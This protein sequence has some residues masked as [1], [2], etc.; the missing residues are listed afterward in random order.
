MTKSKMQHPI[1]KRAKNPT[2]AVRKPKDPNAPKQLRGEALKAAI[3][4]AI[5]QQSAVAQ[6]KREVYTYNASH[7]ARAVPCARKSLDNHAE[8]IQDILDSLG[9]E[10]RA[11]DGGVMI[12][13]L[14]ARIAQ[15]ESRNKELT[16]ENQAL[17][18][19]HIAIYDTMALQSVPAFTLL[20]DHKSNNDSVVP[21]FKP[22]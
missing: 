12:E 9:S 7:V 1:F 10:R 16:E 21:F 4:T 5:E 18:A 15:L 22:D 6:S 8:F 17:A 20:R 2:K 3:R 13:A 19:E 11:R 14:R